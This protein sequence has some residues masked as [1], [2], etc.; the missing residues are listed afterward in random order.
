MAIEVC[1]RAFGGFSVEVDGRPVS[2]RAWKAVNARWLFLYLLLKRGEEVSEDRLRDLFWPGSPV[3]KGQRALIT[4]VYRAR[5]ALGHSG[6]IQRTGTGYCLA[7]NV[8]LRFDVEEYRECHRR[9]LAGGTHGGSEWLERMTALRTGPFLPECADQ[10]CHR[11]R[12]E[13]DGLLK[14]VQHRPGQGRLG[15]TNW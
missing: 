7:P 12:D 8:C 9:I 1:V 13:L 2:G 11:L 3:E 6:L 10:W 15:L 14:S 4:A 5:R